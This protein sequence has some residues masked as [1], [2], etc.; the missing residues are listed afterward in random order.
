MAVLDAAGGDG[1]AGQVTP[2][3]VGVAETGRL[4]EEAARLSQRRLRGYRCNT[5]NTNSQI[6]INRRDLR[7]QPA[8]SLLVS[9][10]LKH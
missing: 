6:M 5:E 10:I 4:A 1:R 9:V 3:H 2:Q 7:L 8:F